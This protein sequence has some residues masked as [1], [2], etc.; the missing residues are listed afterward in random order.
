MTGGDDGGDNDEVAEVEKTR[1][2]VLRGP[3]A[4]AVVLIDTL[5]LEPGRLELAARRPNAAVTELIT[6]DSESWMVASSA[7]TATT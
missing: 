3:E 5:V 4:V 2:D 1:F 6:L 7:L